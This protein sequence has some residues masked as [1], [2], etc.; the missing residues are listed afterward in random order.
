MLRKL[1]CP[2]SPGD[3]GGSDDDEEEGEGGDDAKILE[4]GYYFLGS[5]R[6]VCRVFGMRKVIIMRIKIVKL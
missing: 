6:P 1:A 3:G 5:K 4:L 2:V